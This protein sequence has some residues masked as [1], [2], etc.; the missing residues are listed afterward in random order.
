MWNSQLAMTNGSNKEMLQ[1]EHN[2]IVSDHDEDVA[3]VWGFLS[4]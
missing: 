4:S 3:T 1:K 2:V